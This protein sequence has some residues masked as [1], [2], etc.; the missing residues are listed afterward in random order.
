MKDIK[1]PFTYIPAGKESAT[2]V[3]T[4]GN[5]AASFLYVITGLHVLHLVGGMVAIF[6]VF[7]R[8][9][10]GKYRSDHFGG[11]SVCAIYW[12]F[13]GGLWIY[14]YLFLLYIR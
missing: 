3:G 6:V 8:A 13:M 14:L 4:T 11:V 7:S 10:L 9:I 1:T 12:H 5:V 2:D